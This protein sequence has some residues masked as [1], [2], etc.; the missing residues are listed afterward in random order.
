M[1]KLTNETKQ[2]NDFA[3]VAYIINYAIILLEAV[4]FHLRLFLLFNLAK[5]YNHNV[6]ILF[7]KKIMF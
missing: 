4:F 1:P 6:K 2:K 5:V 7:L 3:K